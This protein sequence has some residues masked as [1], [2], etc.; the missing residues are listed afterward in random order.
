MRALKVFSVK[1]GGIKLLVRLLPSIADVDAEYRAGSRRRDGL[2]VHA[3][4]R[5]SS[6]DQ[7]IHQGTIALGMDADL[8]DVVPHE[9]GHAVIHCMRGI[10]ANDDEA[11][12]TALG[13]LSSQIL[14][15]A[16]SMQEKRRSDA[17]A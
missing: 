8:D 15:T 5:P 6:S 4:F 2:I 1:S 7:A 17:A 12:A 13:L 11:A 9:V 14:K 10:S 16:R 3:Y